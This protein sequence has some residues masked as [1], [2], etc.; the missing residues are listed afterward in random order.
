MKTIVNIIAILAFVAFMVNPAQ[1]WVAKQSGPHKISYV[2]TLNGFGVS[3]LKFMT[4]TDGG[5]SWPEK[6]INVSLNGTLLGIKFYNTSLG[7]ILL[8]SGSIIRTNDAGNTWQYVYNGNGNVLFDLCFKDSLVVLACGEV[9]TIIRST[10]GGLTWLDH[11]PVLNATFYQM[12]YVNG[13]YFVSSTATHYTSKLWS[14][15]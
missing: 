10:N 4:T 5:N 14:R 9:G 7:F 3:T 2:T 1:A 13:K 11:S 6:S 12:V 15:Y 8:S